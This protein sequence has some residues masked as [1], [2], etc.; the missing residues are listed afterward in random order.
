MAAH[1]R[2]F[3]NG[4][5]AQFCRAAFRIVTIGH[6][7]DAGHR[8]RGEQVGNG[9]RWLDEPRVSMITT[10]STRHVRAAG[11]MTWSI[12]TENQPGQSVVQPEVGETSEAR[13]NSGVWPP[14]RC[15]R[16]M[17]Q[18]HVLVVIDA[19]TG[20]RLGYYSY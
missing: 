15:L 11:S 1:C 13:P 2:R 5:P 12:L 20:K 9:Q 16:S 14:C 19:T 8:T 4:P 3:R 7:I 10:A 18:R 17:R 6:A